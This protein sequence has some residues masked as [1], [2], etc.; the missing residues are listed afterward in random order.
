MKKVL[1]CLIIGLMSTGLVN[2]SGSLHLEKPLGSIVNVGTSSWRLV[3]FNSTPIPSNN[4]VV[5]VG[6]SAV[7]RN[8]NGET[9]VYLSICINGGSA[10]SNAKIFNQ[11]GGGQTVVS[12]AETPSPN[13]IQSDDFIIAVWVP[14]LTF[15]DN[16]Y[17]T[18]NDGQALDDFH[19]ISGGTVTLNINYELDTDGDGVANS[20]DDDDD[21]DGVPDSE[22]AFPL[23]PSEVADTD[24]DGIGN[25]ADTDDDNDGIADVEDPL[26]LE[27]NISVYDQNVDG[28]TDILWRNMVSGDNYFYLMSGSNID[29]IEPLNPVNV[30]EN[31]DAY[32][33]D[34]NGDN[35]GDALWRNRVSLE[36]WIWEMQGAERIRLGLV[37]FKPSMDWDI[38]IGDVNG[39]RSSDVVLRNSITGVNWV[40]LINNGEV[41]DDGQINVVNDQAWEIVSVSDMNGDGKGDL[42][43]QNITTGQ[44]YVYYM[45]GMS[46][47]SGKSLIAP[48][49]HWELVGAADFSMSGSG[50]LLFRN[51]SSG[52]LYLHLVSGAGELN[53]GGTVAN[54]TDM[55]WAIVQLSDFD[56]DNHA[57]I[58]WRHLQTGQNWMYRMIDN[59]IIESEQVNFVPLDWD[60]IN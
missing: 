55:N 43:W 58:L 41:L 57:D 7:A 28:K 25:N 24:N 31:W 13:Q 26:P 37:P 51:S 16:G 48:P 29:V 45:N 54:V 40:Y 47:L 9:P 38:F 50:D 23:D 4:V 3:E 30:P 56:G 8:I 34:F 33:G 15:G 36:L 17:K 52:E 2:A 21:N 5:S 11:Y 10:C 53:G 12:G 14:P 32:R 18:G 1:L 6:A 20:L 44:V 60:V 27:P 39:D 35:V 19:R 22:D 59:N 42:V 49:N 46:I